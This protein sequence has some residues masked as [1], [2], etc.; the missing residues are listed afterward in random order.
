MRTSDNDVTKYSTHSSI[1]LVDN[2]LYTIV[3]IDNYK[4]I[5]QGYFLLIFAENLNKDHLGSQ[6]FLA[7]FRSA[8]RVSSLKFWK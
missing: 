7:F 8:H 1:A 2:R 3:Y 6:L 5:L 4:S